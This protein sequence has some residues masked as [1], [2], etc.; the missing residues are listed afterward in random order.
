MNTLEI[1]KPVPLTRG[2]HGKPTI[3]IL[4][5]N[6]MSINQAV[7]SL[8]G[9]KEK[10]GGFVGFAR[11]QDREFYIVPHQKKQADSFAIQ[12]TG[13]ITD[14]LLPSKIA[15]H[16]KLQPGLKSSRV[17]VGTAPVKIDGIEMY[18]LSV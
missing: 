8:L 5:D 11:D 2:S 15:A 12:S 13:K 14:L 6:K 10:S 3:L 9:I 4:S 16:F 7:L 18:K 17:Y 1:L